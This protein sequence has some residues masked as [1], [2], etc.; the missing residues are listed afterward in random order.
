LKLNG[1]QQLLVYANYVNIL[2]ERVHTVKETAEAFVMA[3]K[4]TGLEVNFDK[5]KYMITSRDRNEG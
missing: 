3:S 1:I 2:G 4:E 5:T